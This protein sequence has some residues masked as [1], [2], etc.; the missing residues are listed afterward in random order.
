MA[1]S[2]EAAGELVL[3]FSMDQDGKERVAVS[4]DR[5]GDSE[6]LPRE[7]LRIYRSGLASPGVEP[8]FP[9]P[10]LR[11]ARKPRRLVKVRAAS[12]SVCALS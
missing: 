8:D 1:E 9:V 6:A 3:S 5:D 11:S 2:G 7:P 4:P 12:Y 10:G